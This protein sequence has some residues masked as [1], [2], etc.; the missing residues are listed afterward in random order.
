MSAVA[1][2]SVYIGILCL[3]MHKIDGTHG[4]GGGG[5]QLESQSH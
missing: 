4:E 5:C 1:C 3:C 2:V